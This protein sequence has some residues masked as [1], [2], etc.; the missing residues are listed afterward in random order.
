MAER[1]SPA[2]GSYA[3]FVAIRIARG[4][5]VHAIA[6]EERDR[7]DLAGGVIGGVGMP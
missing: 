7:L 1:R 4:L 5:V 3:W 2:H 6:L